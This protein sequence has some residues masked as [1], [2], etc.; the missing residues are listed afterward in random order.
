MRNSAL[1]EFSFG[2]RRG[3]GQTEASFFQVENR[4][5]GLLLLFIA[6]GFPEQLLLNRSGGFNLKADADK[7]Q[8]APGFGAAV[9][10]G[11]GALQQGGRVGNA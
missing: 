9:E 7:P 6:V 2:K 5:V 1:I 3:L 4:T 10:K 8:F 11:F